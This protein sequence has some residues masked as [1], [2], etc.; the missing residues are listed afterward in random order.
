[1]EHHA[2]RVDGALIGGLNYKL[3]AG[4]SYVTNRRS[5]PYFAQGGN[6]YSPNGVKVMKSN[7]PGDQWL[8]PSTCRVA[9]QL[10]NKEYDSAGTT[11]LQPLSWNPAVF[12]RRCRIIAG[13]AVIEYVDNFN[14]LSL[15]LHALKSEEE[16][17][18]IV[19][20]R[21]SSFGDKH[22]N[23]ATDIRKSYRFENHDQS[24]TVFAGRRVMFKP[25]VGLSKQDK[26]VPLRFCPITIELGLA[27]N[28]A[29]AV[30]V[31]MTPAE[32]IRQ[33]GILMISHVSV[34]F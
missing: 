28:G 17:L 18:G 32:N 29:D 10:N 15:M 16:Q 23:V 6:Q 27:S 20:E 19:A 11:Y 3:Q 30:F 14:R 34:T 7:L 26:L 31:D 9:F 4:A 5:V 21:F 2:Q 1:M 13:G 25:L 8:D 12:F 22:A 24:G 33:I